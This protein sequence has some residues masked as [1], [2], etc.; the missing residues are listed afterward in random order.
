M[1]HRGP[2]QAYGSDSGWITVNDGDGITSAQSGLPSASIEEGGMDGT[3]A[4]VRKGFLRKPQ[5]L[6]A[7]ERIR[8]GHPALS[9]E[10]LECVRPAP[11]WVQ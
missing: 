2:E 4:M 10:Y 7:A 1:I 9:S 3:S 8:V 6:G 11:R 5:R